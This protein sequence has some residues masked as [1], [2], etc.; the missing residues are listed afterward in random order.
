VSRLFNV[1]QLL[2]EPVGSTRTLEVVD[3][4]PAPD[5]DAVTHIRGQVRLIRTDQGIWTEG[6]V[7]AT[8]HAECSRCLV[9]FSRWVTLKLSGEFLPTVDIQTGRR[10]K[11]LQDVDDSFAIDGYHTLDLTEAIRQYTIAA[12]PLQPLCQAQCQGICSGCGADLNEGSCGCQQPIDPRW[13]PL[14]NMLTR[15]SNR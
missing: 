8:V 13:A 1:A 4:L 5:G 14:M 6:S 9:R 3:E 2:K 11:H 15:N 12:T 7:D 10:L